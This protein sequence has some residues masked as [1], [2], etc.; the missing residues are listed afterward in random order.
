MC[1]SGAIPPT[2]YADFILVPSKDHHTVARVLL[3]YGFEFSENYS[4]YLEPSTLHS[5]VRSTG[6]DA[7]L[8]P[9]P[10]DVAELHSR[11][12]SQLKKGRIHPFTESGLHLV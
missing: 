1:L 4:A 10:S 2:Y 11:A 6:T 3:A 8:T 9:P 5:K 7:P 12:F